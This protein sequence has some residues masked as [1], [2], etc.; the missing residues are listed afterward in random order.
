MQDPKRIV[1]VDDDPSLLKSLGRLL[2]QHSFEPVLFS[3]AQEFLSHA[4]FQEACCIVLDI[5]LQD[6]SGIELRDRLA[7]AGVTT[8]VIFMTGNTDERT[9]ERALEVGCFSFLTK[10]FPAHELLHPLQQLCSAGPA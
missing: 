10:P 7:R 5:N 8:P 3:S 9:R 4:E 6:G 1:V 2:R